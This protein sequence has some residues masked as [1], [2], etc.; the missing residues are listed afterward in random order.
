MRIHFKSFCMMC[1]G[2]ALAAC[3]WSE[4]DSAGGPL[5]AKYL[6]RDGYLEYFTFRVGPKSWKIR[7]LNHATVDVTMLSAPPA[8][9]VQVYMCRDKSDQPLPFTSYDVRRA[10]TFYHSVHGRILRVHIMGGFV[11][12]PADSTRFKV[13][14][15]GK[16]LRRIYKALRWEDLGEMSKLFGL[17][18]EKT[19]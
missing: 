6:R 19:D 17:P 3:R 5:A 12:I 11:N 14:S 16:P 4:A 8:D 18:D 9:L 13:L 1:L 10:M 15:P 2:L 7:S